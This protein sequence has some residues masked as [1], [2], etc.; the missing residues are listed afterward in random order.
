MLPVCGFIQSPTEKNT[1]QARS[2]WSSSSMLLQGCNPVSYSCN[3]LWYKIVKT[4]DYPKNAIFER[5]KLW[6]PLLFFSPA[7]TQKDPPI[8]GQANW[9]PEKTLRDCSA[10]MKD[11]EPPCPMAEINH[12]PCFHNPGIHQGSGVECGKKSRV[13]SLLQHSCAAFFTTNQGKNS[14]LP[15][16]IDKHQ[17]RQLTMNTTF[18]K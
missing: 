9:E 4:L 11:L 14:F 1:K 13:N 17:K 8:H 18:E 7:V 10:G 12:S 3:R 2:L 6:D 5:K 15:P 16:I